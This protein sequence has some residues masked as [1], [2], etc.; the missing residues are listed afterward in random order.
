MSQ[1][2]SQN[3]AVMLFVPENFPENPR[4]APEEY[5]INGICPFITLSILEGITL[6]FQLWSLKKELPVT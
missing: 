2:V 4:M 5:G 3:F 6:N 1:K